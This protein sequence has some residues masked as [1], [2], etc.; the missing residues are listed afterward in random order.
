MQAKNKC[1]PRTPLEM[2]FLKLYGGPWHVTERMH[3]S[4]DCQPYQSILSFALSRNPEILH[5]QCSGNFA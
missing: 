3:P 5:S 4:T 1:H 2:Q